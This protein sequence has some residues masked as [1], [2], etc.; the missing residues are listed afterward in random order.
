MSINDSSPTVEKVISN[1]PVRSSSLIE[2]GRKGLPTSLDGM[3]V[4]LE[5]IFYSVKGN[6]VVASFDF[7]VFRLLPNNIEGLYLSAIFEDFNEAVGRN[8]LFKRSLLLIKAWCF[9][10]SRRFSHESES[11]FVFSAFNL[12]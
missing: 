3:K 1:D 6:C 2:G 10:E 11:T 12:F 9:F 8:D 4:V 7:Q 5:N